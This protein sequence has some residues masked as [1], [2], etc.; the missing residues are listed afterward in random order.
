MATLRRTLA[1]LLGFLGL[2]PSEKVL[3]EELRIHLA[4]LTREHEKAGLDPA[5]AATRAR[6]DLMLETTKEEW[7]D[8]RSFPVLEQVVQDLR[9]AA[10]GLRRD[11]AFTSAAV[12]TLALGLAASTVV[13]SL[14]EGVLLRPL[15][16]PEPKQLVRVFET[17][18]RFAR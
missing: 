9:H 14:I 4:E 17:S 11:P 10:R 16:Y 2:G 12:L 3:D 13:Y 6:Q 7:R 18:A 1:R 5:R 8:E 15:P